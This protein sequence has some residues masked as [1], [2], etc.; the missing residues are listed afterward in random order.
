M[1][2]LTTTPWIALLPSPLLVVVV[3]KVDPPS[4]ET[5]S[6]LSVAA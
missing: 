3:V 6:P 5:L 1:P 4:V 2:S